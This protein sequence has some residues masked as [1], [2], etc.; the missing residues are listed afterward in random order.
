MSDVELIR[1]Q[2][3]IP[4][5]EVQVRATSV[6]S[7][8][9]MGADGNMESLPASHFQ[10]ELIHLRCTQLQKRSEKVYQLANR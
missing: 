9:V 7:D 1:Y 10:W 2:V 4:V 5:N 6:R 8:L 3:L